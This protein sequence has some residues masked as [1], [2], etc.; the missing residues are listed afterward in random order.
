M[1]FEHTAENQAGHCDGLLE[2]VAERDVAKP[3]AQ[4]R[5]ARWPVDAGDH[6]VDE[7]RNIEFFTCAVQVV[8]G[9]V[10]EV[11]ARVGSDAHTDESE[12]FDGMNQFVDRGRD[13]LHRKRGEGLEPARRRRAPL[14]EEFVVATRERSSDIGVDVREI[15][16]RRAA[17]HLDLDPGLVDCCETLIGRALDGADP[18]ERVGVPAGGQYGNAVLVVTQARPDVTCATEELFEEQVGVYVDHRVDY[19]PARFTTA[20]RSTLRSGSV[21]PIV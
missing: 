1:P 11:L 10:V 17:Y 3:P 19:R 4:A 2:G 15:P 13:V 14:R 21:S 12:V 9:R 18:S 8:E 5:V 16:Q 6:R 7:Q 20:V